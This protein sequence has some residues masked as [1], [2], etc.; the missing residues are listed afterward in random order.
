LLLAVLVVMVAGLLYL[1][2]TA[3]GKAWL[4]LRDNAERARFI[5]IDVFRL[6]LIAYAI[7]ATL[8]GIGGV[9]FV[10]FNGAVTPEALS[11]FQSGKILMYVVLGGVGSVVGPALGA[12]VFTFA[13][14][15]ISSFTSAWLVYFGA[16]FVLV[17]VVA[18]GGLH[19]LLK[20]L[21]TRLVSRD[22]TEAPR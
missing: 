8:A 18:P 2:A 12:V 17:V 10:L 21:W 13:E 4:G 5:G 16:L 20:P 14:N 11:W 9:F 15:A 6:K 3:L 19:G 1:R 7:S 22:E